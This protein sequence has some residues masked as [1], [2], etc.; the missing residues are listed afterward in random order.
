MSKGRRPLRQVS[1]LAVVYI[2]PLCAHGEPN[3]FMSDSVVHM[4]YGYDAV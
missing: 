4:F 2:F 1:R 3:I